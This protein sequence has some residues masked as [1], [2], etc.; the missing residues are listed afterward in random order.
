MSTPKIYARSES[1]RECVLGRPIDQIKIEVVLKAGGIK[2][3]KWLLG[4]HTLLFILFGKKLIFVKTTE[5]R[6]G[7]SGV[8][9]L[10]SHSKLALVPALFWDI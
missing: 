9:V 1:D 3:L 5:N 8:L 6:Q 2:D 7:Y 10:A 4:N